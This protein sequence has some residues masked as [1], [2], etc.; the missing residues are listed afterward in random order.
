MSNMPTSAPIDAFDP[1]TVSEDALRR[2][3]RQVRRLR[4]WITHA[5]IYALVVTA[6]WLG[7][8]VSG[9]VGH[10][11]FA[12]PLGPTL[13]WGLGVAI[14]GFVVWAKTS[15]LAGN[16]EARQIERVLRAERSN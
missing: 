15:R 1:S 6:L 7:W 5:G 8:M 12:W 2:A 4:G 14:H 10:G 16:W 3:R 13:G 11:R 9:N